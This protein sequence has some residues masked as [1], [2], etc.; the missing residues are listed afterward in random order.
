MRAATLILR[1]SPL[2]LCCGLAACGGGGGGGGGG[3]SEAPPGSTT[4]SDEARASAASS[5]ALSRSNACAAVRPFYWEVGDR[6]GRLA[7][8]AAPSD[9]GAMPY[10]ADTAMPIAS[11]S[12][13][14]YGAYVAQRRAG[15]LSAQ[16]IQFLNF[17]SGYTNFGFSGCER[18]DTVGS[19]MSHGNNALLTPEHVGKFYYNGGHMQ[20]H[21]QGL[22]LAALDKAGLA[23]EMNT[24]LGLP[25]G[26]LAYT[27]PQ[28]A[29]GAY[30]SASGY[31]RFLRRL[32]A[33]ELQLSAQLGRNPVCTNPQSCAEALYTPISGGLDWHYSLGHWVEDDA[34]RGD[35]AFSSPGAFG[36]YPW[37]DASQ[38]YYGI[39]AR[40]DAGGS[41]QESASCGALIRRAWL[42]AQAQ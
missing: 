26:T 18:D 39:V 24:A 22:G 31:A 42:S 12:K 11:A 29:G 28:L 4:P 36:F 9:S 7:G 19:C 32:L 15:Q 40:V 1:M 27:Q 10:G 3:G 13:W 20:Q 33:G 8:A 30:T 34:S 21:A 2:A 23:A 14:L 5:T 35:G 41:G 25:A 16:D 6:N 38:R 37:I 17:R